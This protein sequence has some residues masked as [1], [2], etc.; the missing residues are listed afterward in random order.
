MPRA[1]AAERRRFAGHVPCFSG[2][3]ADPAELGIL[4][5]RRS[6]AHLPGT[7]MLISKAYE[8]NGLCDEEVGAPPA[9][10]Q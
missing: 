5:R 1:A 8:T 7:T 3:P 9:P 6:D 4:V 10:G 2:T